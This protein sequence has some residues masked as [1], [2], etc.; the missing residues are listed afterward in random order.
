MN[1]KLLLVDPTPTVGIKQ[2]NE[3]TRLI[4][5]KK[6]NKDKRNFLCLVVFLNNQYEKNMVNFNLQEF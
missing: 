2:S 5:K 6:K 3:L 4:I 1:S